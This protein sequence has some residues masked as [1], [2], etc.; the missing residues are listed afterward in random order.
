MQKIAESLH[1][2]DATLVGDARN[3]ANKMRYQVGRLEKRATQAE[4]RK[5]EILSRHAAMIENSLYPKRTLQEREIAGVYFLSRH[6][7][8]LMDQLIEAASAHC[9]EHKIL[10]VG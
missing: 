7:A 3:A 4:L 10:R 9:P 1:K 2:L 8:P 6:G 5:E